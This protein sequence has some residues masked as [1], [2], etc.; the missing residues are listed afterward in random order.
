MPQSDMDSSSGLIMGVIRILTNSKDDNERDIIK[1]KLED[2]LVISDQKLTKLVSENHKELRLVM[3]SFANISN[4]LQ[5]SLT[6]IGK[7]KQ[8]LKDSKEMLMSRLEELQRLCTESVRN[9]KI[10]ALLDEV[11]EKS[12]VPADV[13]DLLYDSKYLEATRLL[14]DNIHQIEDNADS[15]DL[16]KDVRQDMDCKREELY[17]ILRERLMSTDDQQVKDEIVESLK[18]IDKDPQMPG[19]EFT[20][21]D[22]DGTPTS[23]PSLFKFSRSSHAICFNEH[24]KAQNEFNYL[25]K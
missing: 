24:Y 20:K 23:K 12:R 22:I 4:N 18:L 3:Q 9:E 11:A 7:A 14:V 8:R 21:N 17:G 6:R 16:F 13:T 19:A 2:C 10:L 1:K 5:S 15:F 25:N